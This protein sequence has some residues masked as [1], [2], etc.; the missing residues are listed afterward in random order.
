MIETYK[1]TCERHFGIAGIEINGIQPEDIQVYNQRFY[2][3]VL[4]QGSIGLGESYMDGWWDC[5]RLDEFF[6]K[7]LKAKLNEKF[8]KDT[9]LNSIRAKIFNPQNIRKSREVGEKHYDIG[10]ELYEKMLGKSMVYSCGYWKGVD[11][12][13]QA[14]EDKLE[15][16][17]KKVELEPDMRVLDIGCGWGS[18]AEYASRKHKVEVTGLTIS[19]EQKKYAEERYIGQRVDIRLED[20]RDF[21]PKGKFDA[22]VSIGMFEQVGLNNYR[23]FMEKAEECLDNNGLFLLHTIGKNTPRNAGHKEPWINKHIFPG[24]FL[25]SVSQIAKASER[26]FTMEDW[27]NFGK[28]YDTTLMAWH[29]NLTDNW[30]EIKEKGNYDN[31]FKRMFDYYLMCCA[32]AFRSSNNRL[33]QIVFSKGRDGRYDSIR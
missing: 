16:I 21:E 10:N 25:P 14:Q 4:A 17:C 11:N 33:W 30:D 6:N 31:R 8:N 22:I 27:H 9:F 24:G 20:Y 2:Q 23:T 29:K 3:R 7:L 26:L 1:Q 12:L 15:L 18:F 28:D 32:G 5:H 19:K 13:D